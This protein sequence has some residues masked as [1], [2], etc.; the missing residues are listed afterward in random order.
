MSFRAVAIAIFLHGQLSS[1]ADPVY[2]FTACAC[3]NVTQNTTF[4]SVVNYGIGLNLDEVKIYGSSGSQLPLTVHSWSQ[5]HVG[6]CGTYGPQYTI[7]GQIWNA[8]YLSSGI[9]QMVLAQRFP[10]FVTY[11]VLGPVA[12]MVIYDR[13]TTA[14]GWYRN[15]DSYVIFHNSSTAGLAS[16][17]RPGNVTMNISWQLDMCP[18]G[19]SEIVSPAVCP[20]FSGTFTFECPAACPWSSSNNAAIWSVV[21]AAGAYKATSCTSTCTPCPTG[22]FN[23]N[24]GATSPA[25][26]QQ[27]PGGYYC[28]NKTA[29]ISCGRGSYCPAGSGAPTL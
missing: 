3:S 15:L 5:C 9:N 18:P 2:N 4:V 29:F 1:S 10:S 12:K 6:N 16:S 27:C 21:C 17:F 7:D 28:P 22:T 14:P 11:R 19:G 24:S 26:C 20:C 8:G 13:K 25:S 23:P